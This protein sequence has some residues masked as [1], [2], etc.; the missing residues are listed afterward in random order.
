[1]YVKCEQASGEGAGDTNKCVAKGVYDGNE[2]LWHNC[3]SSS[4]LLITSRSLV[5]IVIEK[6][7]NKINVGH[8]HPA[9]AIPSEAQSIHSISAC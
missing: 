5:D 9:T 4:I 2:Y 3:I 1:M 6:L 8:H 7:L